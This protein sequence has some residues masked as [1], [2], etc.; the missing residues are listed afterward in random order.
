MAGVLSAEG[1]GDEG[2]ELGVACPLPHRVAQRDLG[3][4]KQAHLRDAGRCGEMW[5]RCGG[6]VG[7]M[8]G[9][10]C[11]GCGGDAG[12]ISEPPDSFTLSDP[13]AVSRSRLQP[14][15]KGSVIDEM[16]ETDPSAP[17]QE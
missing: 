13:S 11:G 9:E 8:C 3:A 14:P 4:A 15:Q 16:K 2:E 1:R 6:D 10:M 7:E 12:E 17:G 5:R